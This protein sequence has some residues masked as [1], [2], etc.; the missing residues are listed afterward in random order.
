MYKIWEKLEIKIDPT[1]ICKFK[2]N[3]CSCDSDLYISKALN[4]QTYEW[5][6]NNKPYRFRPNGISNEHYGS[7]PNITEEDKI[8]AIKKKKKKIHKN[9]LFFLFFST[10]K[11]ENLLVERKSNPIQTC[12]YPL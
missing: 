9:V 8:I 3:S 6:L 7:L 12:T 2:Q 10:F 4:K 1:H 11:I 5:F